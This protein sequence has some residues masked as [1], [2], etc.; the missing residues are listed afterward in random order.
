MDR[1]SR[2]DFIAASVAGCNSDEFFFLMR[3]PEEERLWKIPLWAMEDL[4]AR[5]QAPVTTDDGSILRRVRQ[6]VVRRIAVC[7]EMDERRFEPLQ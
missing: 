6:N 3:T 1:M 4:A 2:A 7:L 5:F